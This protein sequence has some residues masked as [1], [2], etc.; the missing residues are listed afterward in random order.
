[1]PDPVATPAPGHCPLCA[2]EHDPA[3]SESLWQ[4]WKR[5][6][7]KPP[8]E[9]LDMIEWYRRCL[10]DVMRHRPVRGLDEAKAGYDT[11]MA[12]LKESYVL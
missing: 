10:E 8:L 9:L 2:D 11:A 3:F 4:E 6:T 5:Q 12:K 7:A 1:M